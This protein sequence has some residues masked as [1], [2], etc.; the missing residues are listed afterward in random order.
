MKHHQLK[1]LVQV[2]EQGSIRGAARALHLSQS[3]LTKALRELEANVGAELLVRSYKGVEFTPAGQALLTRA[4]L[5]LSTLDKARDEIRWLR[6]GAGIQITAGVTPAIAATALPSVLNEFERE[7]PDASLT[8]VE[9]MLTNVLPGLME[10]RIDFAIAV[11]EPDDL[12]YEIAFEPLGQILV[13]AAAR[14]GHPM[15]AATE[16]SQLVGARWVLNL[17][18]GSSAQQLVAW[19]ERQGLGLSRQVV[20]CDSPTLMTEMMRRTDLIGFGPHILF[21]DPLSGQGL[22]SFDSLPPV[23]PITLGLLKLRGV[24]LHSG[25]QR[26]ATLFTRYI[27]PSQIQ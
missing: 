1:A 7:Q 22:A 12:P 20:R 2:A 10:G 21:H 23:P 5:A 16:W 11:A 24:P 18:A 19:L 25:A 8:L 13:E 4:R 9:G 27:T 15:L 3:A 14:V 6:G 26:L 17:A